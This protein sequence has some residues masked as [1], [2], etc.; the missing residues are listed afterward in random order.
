MDAR[1]LLAAAM[2]LGIVVMAPG[3]KGREGEAMKPTATGGSTAT[4]PA[5]TRKVMDSPIAGSWYTDDPAALRRE[6]ADYLES[7]R[8]DAA[9]REGGRI[10]GLVSPHA[11]YRYSGAVAGHGYALLAGQDVARVIVLAPSHR[12]PFQ[13]FALP[14]ATAWRTPLGE[15]PIDVDA[16]ARL[17]AQPGFAVRQDAFAQEHSLDI[18]VPFVQAVAPRAVLVPI[19]VGRIDAEQARRAGELLRGLADAR[20]VIVAS[21]DFTHYGASFGYV[22]FREDVPEGLKGLA[23]AAVDALVRRDAEG[24][25]AHLDRTG[26]TICGEA[27]IRVLLAALPGEA[28]GVPLKYDNSGRM[29]GDWRQS[30]SYVSVAFRIPSGTAQFQGIQ[31]FGREEQR[32]LV[33]LARRTIRDHLSGRGRPDPAREGVAIPAGVRE[34]YGVFVTLKADG[35]LRG[36]I[37]SILPTEPLWQGVIRNAINAAVH[38]P[39]FR[40]LTAAEEP[41]VEIEVSVLTPP[42]DVAGWRDIVIGRDGVILAR[43]GNRA[44][45]LPQVAPEQGWDLAQTLTHLSLKAGLPSDAW[46]T[47]ATFQVFQAQVIEERDVAGEGP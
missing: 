2:G 30:V 46:R 13:G 21:S 44:V 38:D 5:S 32:F 15:M 45:F 17:A 16:L 42:R 37:G 24:F 28:V 25:A 10:V 39:R 26:D 31:V 9:R 7:A 4:A 29:T 1:G 36:C 33:R 8:V 34:P 41:G 18:Q 11:G 3:C 12:V 20:T 14:D 23:D 43:G 27:P 47:G 22:P 35:D 19:V 40:P 6:I